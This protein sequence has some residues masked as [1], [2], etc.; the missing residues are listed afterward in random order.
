M[1]DLDI[2]DK[3]LSPKVVQGAISRAKDRLISAD[4]FE[5][6]HDPRSRDVQKIYKLYT[7]RMMTNNA[8][9]FDDIIMQT[10]TLL[11]TYSDVRE[12]Y[13][14]KFRYILVDEYQDTNYAQFVLTEILAGKHRNIM[15]VGDDDQ[16]I[17]RFRG[18]TIE[19]ILNFDI[20]SASAIASGFSSPFSTPRRM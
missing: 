14:N 7:E 8:V 9:D 15:V 2:D 6:S 5:L 16:S 13:Q 4:D 12:Y 20:L 3:K 18:A 11:N 10:V 19:N 1:H 17:Y